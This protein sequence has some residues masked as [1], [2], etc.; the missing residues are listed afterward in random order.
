MTATIDDFIPVIRKRFETLRDAEGNLLYGNR[1]HLSHVLKRIVVSSDLTEKAAIK[2][3]EVISHGVSKEIPLTQI[4][5]RLGKLVGYISGYTPK[6]PPKIT[7][8]GICSMGISILDWFAQEGYITVKKFRMTGDKMREQYMILPK[9]DFADICVSGPATIAYIDPTEGPIVWEKPMMVKDGFPYELVKGSAKAKLLHLHTK[10]AMPKVYEAV[11][12]MNAEEWIVNDWIIHLKET[13]SEDNPYIPS[14]IDEDVIELARRNV[15]IGE[16]SIKKYKLQV[17]NEY[18]KNNSSTMEEKSTIADRIVAKTLKN[19]DAKLQKLISEFSK[20][21]DHHKVYSLA[22]RFQGSV[23]NF[24]YFMDSRGRGYSFQDY[25]NPLGNDFAKSLLLYKDAHPVNLDHLSITIAN[26]M[27]YDKGTY[28]ERIQSASDMMP[29]ILRM[30]SDPWGN[31]EELMSLELG[32]KDKW[33][34]LAAAREWYL[35]TEFLLEGGDIADYR[36]HLPC[37]RDGSNQAIQILSLIGKDEFCGPMVNVAPCI[38]EDGVYVKGD[39]YGYIGSFLSDAL[40]STDYAS[41]TM[42]SFIQALEDQPQRARKVCK[43]NVMTKSYGGTKFGFGE[44]HVEDRVDYEFDEA[45]DLTYKD[46]FVLGK[47]IYGLVDDKFAKPSELMQWMMDCVDLIE[48]DNPTITWKLPDGFTAFAT[49]SEKTSA[50]V[51]GKIG[52]TVVHLKLHM[53]SKNKNVTKHKLAIAPNIVHSLDALIM[54]EIRRNM[55]QDAPFSSVH[56]SFSTTSANIDTL[57]HIARDAYKM[58]TDRKQFED[59][60]SGLCGKDVVLPA[61]G[62]LPENSLN[63]TDYFI[64]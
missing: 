32:K 28:E 64:S 61:A 50:A 20:F 27:G 35:I 57:V 19:K 31:I 58:A 59:I 7:E 54:R 22:K 48:S 14:F 63:D 34:F 40:K 60:I 44:Q 3:I 12:K 16:R 56:D 1:S 49:K 41:E 42:V 53:Y 36:S 45:E 29:T 46:C 24:C 15:L 6:D 38:D 4:A 21:E 26:L 2:C 55:P 9:G 18:L 5:T 52:K 37:A 33:Q 43:R 30:G 25:F 51:T 11:N 62:L 10:E 39:A 8:M 23:L 13:A 47:T 17:M